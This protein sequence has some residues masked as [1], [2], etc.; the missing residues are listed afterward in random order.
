MKDEIERQKQA[1][2]EAYRSGHWAEFVASALLRL[3]GYKIL[4]RRF[5]SPVGEIDLIAG[6]GDTVIFVEV[7]ARTTRA[8]ALE[9]ITPRQ[10][11]RISRAASWYLARNPKLQGMNCR[12]DVLAMA[13]G[14]LPYHVKNAWTMD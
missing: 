6:R 8:E 4:A 7:K 1:K 9:A 5:R 11:Q 12:F 10:R 14:H 13:R 3:K 2:R